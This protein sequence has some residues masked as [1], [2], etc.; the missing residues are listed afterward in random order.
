M[1]NLARWEPLREMTLRQAMDRLFEILLC[2][3]LV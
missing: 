2:A 3:Q 1:T